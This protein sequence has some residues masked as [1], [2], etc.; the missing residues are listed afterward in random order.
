MASY[1]D[2][3][4]C[5]SGKVIKELVPALGG[6][7]NDSVIKQQPDAV[8]DVSQQAEDITSLPGAIKQCK[9]PLLGVWDSCV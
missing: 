3:S 1:S 2:R 9:K 8:H 4:G 7:S 6:Q 5:G